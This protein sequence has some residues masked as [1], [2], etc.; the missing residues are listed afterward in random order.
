V[1]DPR[2]GAPKGLSVRVER[3]QSWQNKARRLVPLVSTFLKI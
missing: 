3:L 1:D 2:N